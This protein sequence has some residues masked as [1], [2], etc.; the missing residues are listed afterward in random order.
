MS[1]PGLLQLLFWASLFGLVYILAGYPIL[2]GI[3]ACRF[4]RPI[5]RAAWQGSVSVIVCGYNESSRITHRLDNLFELEGAEQITQ[6]LVGSDGSTDGMPEQVACY[7]DQRVELHAFDERRGKAA[8]L[9]DLIP[10]ATGDIVLM[11]DVRQR[12]VSDALLRLTERFA[13]PNVGVVSGELVFRD[14]SSNS[15]AASGVGAYWKYEKLIRTWESNYRSVP[16]ATGAL[17]AIRRSLLRPIHP[18]TLLDDVVIPMQAIEQQ[19][20]CVLEPSAVLMDD[21]SGSSGDEAVRKRRTIAGCAQL[22]INQ[23]RWALPWRNPIWW[24]FMSH[25][26]AR[27]LLPVLLATALVSNLLLLSDRVYAALMVGQAACYVAAMLGWLCQRAGYRSRVLGLF[28]MFL[29]LAGSTMLALWD[30]SRGRFRPAWK[31]TT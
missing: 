5:S 19:Y 9:N 29:T 22:L 14:A 1:T 25:K 8:V 18:A 20:R 26:I 24:E 12:I 28:L 13:D 15:T 10:L 27:L 17:Y 31:R 6:V 23:P 16:G 11:V 3:L 30:A 7:S 21:P 2:I 4:R